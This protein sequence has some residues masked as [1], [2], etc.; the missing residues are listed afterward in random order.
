MHVSD[1]LHI[2]FVATYVM[3]VSYFVM[4]FEPTWNLLGRIVQLQLSSKSWFGL[5]DRLWSSQ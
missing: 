5:Q 3:S 1:E 2:L 4:Q